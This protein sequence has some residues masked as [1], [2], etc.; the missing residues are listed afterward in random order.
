MLDE[1]AS[2]PAP[3][4]RVFG[5]DGDI[6]VLRERLV[7]GDLRVVTLVGTAGVGKTTL[8]YEVARAAEP[9]FPDGVTVVQLTR[10]GP[11][12]DL[13]A[14][15]IR[16]IGVTDQGR[17]PRTLLTTILAP[18]SLLLVLDNCEHVASAAASLLDELMDACPD[19]RVLATS[20]VPLRIRG[21]AVSPVDPVALP[22]LLPDAG[23]RLDELR[24]VPSVALFVERARAAA[25]DFRL[26]ADNAA[27]VVEI[28]RRLD[29][30]PLPIELAAARSPALAPHDIAERLAGDHGL[31]VLEGGHG[32]ERHRTLEAA[33][34][35][36]HELLDPGAQAVFRRLAVFVA[37]CTLESA[38]AVG[39]LGMP[40][41]DVVPHLTTLVDHSLVRREAV[42]GQS[43]YRMLAPVAAYA[44]A[45]LDESAER[46]AATMAH[47]T[48][49][50]AIT[51]SSKPFG[52]GAPED[53]WRVEAEL[54]DL[55]AA[56]HR[57][58]E[59]GQPMLALGLL[60]NVLGYWRIRGMLAEGIVE[61]ERLL[62]RLGP[63]PS[64]VRAAFLS[65]YA[66][67][68]Q[69]SGRYDDAIDR[70]RES[71]AAAAAVG[72]DI[73]RR[74]AI[75]LRGI[76]LREQGDLDAARAAFDEAAELVARE[77]TE[78]SIGFLEAAYGALDLRGGDLDT[79]D[80]H[81]RRALEAFGQ[82]PSWF[83]GSVRTGLGV[84]AHRRGDHAAAREHLTVALEW[85]H[86]YGATI[87]AI[88]AI[89]AAASLALDDRDPARA[90]TLLS[91]ATALRDASA[92]SPSPEQ[93]RLREATL[94]RIRAGLDTR[95]FRTAWTR[96]REMT[97]GDVLAFQAAPPTERAKGRR[98]P[99]G[100]ELTP[101]E[102][103]IAALV[104]EG[105]TNRQIAARLVLSTGTVRIHVERILGKLGMTSRVQVATWY[106][107][108]G[109]GPDRAVPEGDD[110]S[111]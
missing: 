69:V 40:D 77:P 68:L 83:L 14:A 18:R 54:D 88:V 1:I 29:G 109:D 95:R 71:E 110:L 96:G 100:P 7:H 107:T 56:H 104:A 8:A 21:E 93:Q 84:V 26:T 67:Y 60:Q 55:R 82:A 57:A 20:R 79:A 63:T 90:A 44:S 23:A 46:P 30:L 35:W 91:A 15:V 106:L 97:I 25:P 27:D 13:A 22:P 78:S 98:V 64:P 87:E 34:D 28:C 48:R 74:T 2:I 94:E 37:G 108:E 85:L 36:S 31:R 12:D 38:E 65:A 6:E 81:L 51:S 102:R 66:D 72:D 62:E 32:T 61:F 76:A 11:D 75:G 111:A 43:R 59:A 80:A 17:D 9:A 42:G 73:V 101:R 24:A 103:E 19:L 39:G 16:A 10:V 45:R 47:A 49:L 70:A 3:R 50:L 99:H 41:A 92:V 58:Q 5:R 52:Q 86:A 89:E 53:V 4:A 105:L 33:L